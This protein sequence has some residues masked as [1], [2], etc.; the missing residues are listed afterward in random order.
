MLLTPQ[1]ASETVTI[2]TAASAARR[3]NAWRSMEALLEVQGECMRPH[4]APTVGDELWRLPEGGPEMP[5]EGRHC[6]DIIRIS[7]VVIRACDRRWGPCNRTNPA[8]C[9]RR[10]GR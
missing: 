9:S 2:T 3:L 5:A 8:A 4:R 10:T 7:L 6:P 1:P